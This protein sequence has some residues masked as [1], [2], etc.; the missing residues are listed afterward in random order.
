MSINIYKHVIN[1]LLLISNI[2]IDML[3]DPKIINNLIKFLNNA[4]DFIYQSM[5][6]MIKYLFNYLF[7][8]MTNVSVLYIY[9]YIYIY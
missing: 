3:I 4:T 5:N 6:N 1:K 9:I 7:I 2:S 8:I